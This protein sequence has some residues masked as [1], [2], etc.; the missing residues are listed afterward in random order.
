MESLMQLLKQNVKVSA[1]N[2]DDFVS[3]AARF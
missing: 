2:R 3:D 1:E